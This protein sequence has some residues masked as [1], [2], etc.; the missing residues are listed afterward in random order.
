MQKS[1]QRKY[2]KTI[3][4]CCLY[5]L[6]QLH[7]CPTQCRWKKKQD[8]IQNKINKYFLL[9]KPDFINKVYTLKQTYYLSTQAFMSLCAYS[10]SHVRMHAVCDSVS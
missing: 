1:M 2:C 3:N 10:W 5:P 4:V 7:T 9:I 8:F 6:Q